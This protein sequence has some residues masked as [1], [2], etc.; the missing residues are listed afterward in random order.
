MCTMWNW[1]DTSFPFFSLE[2]C[3]DYFGF[4]FSFYKLGNSS[5]KLVSIYSFQANGRSVL[6][7]GEIFSNPDDPS[8]DDPVLH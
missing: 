3:F 2:R 4:V 7:T 5:L 8:D 1:Y 6:V